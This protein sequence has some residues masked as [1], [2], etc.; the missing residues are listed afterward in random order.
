[1]I[2]YMIRQLGVY[3]VDVIKVEGGS[4][5]CRVWM[6]GVGRWSKPRVIIGRHY[7]T[8][9]AATAARKAAKAVGAKAV[10]AAESEVVEP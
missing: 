8:R 2:R 1:M 6:P 9:A 4:V 5:R 10:G 7:P 3:E